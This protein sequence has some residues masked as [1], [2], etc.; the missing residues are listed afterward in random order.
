MS[1]SRRTLGS[2]SHRE[3]PQLR[4]GPRDAS[5][6]EKLREGLPVSTVSRCWECGRPPD[7]GPEVRVGP[8]A[9]F[10]QDAGS[11]R[12]GQPWEGSLSCV[13]GPT[14]GPVFSVVWL[15]QPLPHPLSTHC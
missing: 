12:L 11:Q 7:H 15:S 9:P 8:G 2:D 6:A 5:W 3:G 1:L 14:H 4:Q 10:P 13:P